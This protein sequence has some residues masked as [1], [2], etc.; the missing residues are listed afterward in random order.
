MNVLGVF[1]STACSKSSLESRCLS[2][3]EIHST[4]IPVNLYDGV[5]G[6]EAMKTEITS[7]L[8]VGCVGDNLRLD[9]EDDDF[10]TAEKQNIVSVEQLAEQMKFTDSLKATDSFITLGATIGRLQA[11]KSRCLSIQ[12]I[13]MTELPDKLFN[14]VSDDEVMA[15]EI[16]V[17]CVEEKSDPN[18]RMCTQPEKTNP[19]ATEQLRQEKPMDSLKIIVETSQPVKSTFDQVNI[20]IR[21]SIH[22]NTTEKSIQI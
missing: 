21:F 14:E 12:D 11:A 1:N 8:I 5:S 2:I 15:T 13:H 10:S 3:E 7:E 17:E 9:E 18:E 16:T 19:L 6:N 22:S 20:I 4:E